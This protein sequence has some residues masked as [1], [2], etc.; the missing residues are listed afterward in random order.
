[1]EAIL[2]VLSISTRERGFSSTSTSMLLILPLW[3]CDIAHYLLSH[4][5]EN[6]I[7]LRTKLT[8]GFEHD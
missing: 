8:A 6:R 5:K 2:P 7:I 3:W 4:E 1:M